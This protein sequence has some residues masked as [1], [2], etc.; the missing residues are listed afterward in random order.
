MLWAHEK[1]IGLLDLSVA[2][3]TIDHNILLV[4]R[5]NLALTALI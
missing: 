1:F 3:D 2:F 4:C 5:L